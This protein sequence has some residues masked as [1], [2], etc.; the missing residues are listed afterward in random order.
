MEQDKIIVRRANLGDLSTLRE[1]FV[2]TIIASCKN[3]YS[4]KQISAWTSSA[5]NTLRWEE[6]FSSQIFTVAE[7]ENRII[8]FASL[9]QYKVLDHLFVH[10]DWQ[11]KGIAY[12]LVKEIE[13]LAK[14]RE[15]SELDVEASLTAKGFF[16]KMGFNVLS[17][18]LVTIK[19]VE[20]LNFKMWKRLDS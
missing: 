12:A 19:G 9:Q 14:E 10:K 20:L 8:G 2:E 7:S 18:Q 5:S 3:D 11:R 1:L 17:H 15:V 4:E 16:E 6:K 13:V